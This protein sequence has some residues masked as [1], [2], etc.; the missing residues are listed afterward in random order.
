MSANLV[1]SRAGAYVFYNVKRLLSDWSL[2]A[3]GIGLLVVLYLVFGATLTDMDVRLA[4][5]KF[6]A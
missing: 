3:F 4:H 1:A 6:A 5:G 2:L